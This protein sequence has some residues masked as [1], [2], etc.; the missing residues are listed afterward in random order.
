MVP[1]HQSQ[2]SEERHGLPIP[3]ENIE[4][5]I[6]YHIYSNRWMAFAR[7]TNHN[8]VIGRILSHVF[9]FLCWSRVETFSSVTDEWWSYRN[10]DQTHRKP[11]LNLL[12]AGDHPMICTLIYVLTVE[13]ILT[14]YFVMVTFSDYFFF[15]V[16]IK[17]YCSFLY[18]CIQFRQC[19]LVINYS[20]N[21]NKVSQVRKETVCSWKMFSLSVSPL[22][23]WIIILLITP[24]HLSQLLLY[25]LFS[26]FFK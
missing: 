16:E 2:F 4:H 23:F 9:L 8:R 17:F 25:T 21:R 10:F 22:L 5:A 13:E 6:N 14:I 24:F 19:L 11:S 3:R 20:S 15:C 12:S 7:L 26:L 1:K 18:D